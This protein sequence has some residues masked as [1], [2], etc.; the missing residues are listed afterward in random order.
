MKDIIALDISKCFKY[1]ISPVTFVVINLAY[2]GRKRDLKKLEFDLTEA[3]ELHYIHINN[4]M[5]C[6]TNKGVILM[7]DCTEDI[8]KWLEF[9]ALYPK[10]LGVRRLHDKGA[11]CKRKFLNF[12]NLSPENYEWVM[13][14]TNKLV[15][16]LE[17]AA[18]TNDFCPIKNMSTYINNESWDEWKDWEI[19]EVV[20]RSEFI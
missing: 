20:N 6:I 7:E 3:L 9:K 13:E 17:I 15:V 1:K 18:K 12:I 8:D 11:Y 14:N 5:I 10:T 19:P 4:D 2:L 16:A